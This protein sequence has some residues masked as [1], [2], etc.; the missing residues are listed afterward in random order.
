VARLQDL[1]ESV[2]TSMTALA[3]SFAHPHWLIVGGAVILILGLVGLALF[4][5][6]DVDNTELD[7]GPKLSDKDAP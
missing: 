3:L 7:D 6:T 4:G 2:L 5:R 1:W